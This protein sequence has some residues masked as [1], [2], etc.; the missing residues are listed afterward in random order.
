MDM[1]AQLSSILP[2]GLADHFI[3]IREEAEI[4]YTYTVH[5]CPE[6]ASATINWTP[7]GGAAGIPRNKELGA[8]GT[9]ET[10]T[11]QTSDPTLVG[12]EYNVQSDYTDP[13]WPVSTFQGEQQGAAVTGLVIKPS[14]DI[15]RHQFYLVQEPGALS[16]EEL[17]ELELNLGVTVDGPHLQNSFTDGGSISRKAVTRLSYP[18]DHDRGEV[19]RQ[20]TTV[21]VNVSGYFNGDVHFTPDTTLSPAE[22]NVYVVVAADGLRLRTALH[23]TP[24]DGFVRSL[25]PMETAGRAFA[26]YTNSETWADKEAWAR[27]QVGA[28]SHVVQAILQH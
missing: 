15:G 6:L 10:F 23:P 1:D 18:L 9:S 7:T 4:G 24:V 14:A 11:I 22:F 25:P 2:S 20:P 27:I 28:S 26:D 12:C 8:A 21:T 13:Y 17:D 5:P 3:E 19:G 16:P